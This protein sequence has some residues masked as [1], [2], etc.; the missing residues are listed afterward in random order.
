[1]SYRLNCKWLYRTLQG[2]KC[3]KEAKTIG[4][5]PENCPLY[6]KK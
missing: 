2:R 4:C 1:M 3:D 6:G 5:C